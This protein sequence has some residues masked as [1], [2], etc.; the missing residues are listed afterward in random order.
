MPGAQLKIEH[1][2]ENDEAARREARI[3]ARA[4]AHNN[5]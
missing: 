2:F 1:C 5:Y 4:V 3:V